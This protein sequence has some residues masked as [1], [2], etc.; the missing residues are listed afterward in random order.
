MCLKPLRPSHHLA[1]HR[2]LH[3]AL[4]RDDNGLFH[5]VAHDDSRAGLSRRARQRLCVLCLSHAVLCP[6]FR[7]GRTRLG[8]AHATR[9]CAT[10]LRLRLSISQMRLIDSDDLFLQHGLEPRHILANHAKPEG[11]L[12]GFGSRAEL[13][14]ESLLLQLGDTDVDVAFVHVTDLTTQHLCAPPHE[15]QTWFSRRAWRR[16]VPLPSL[17][18]RASRPR[19]RTSRGQASR[20]L[21]IPRAIPFPYPCGFRRASS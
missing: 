8:P 21:P 12:E 20:L 19:A 7:A 3:P 6:L 5:L 18:S 14:A 16:Q 17:R 1:V 9:L 2:M 15:R 4:D 10:R 13:E 11:I